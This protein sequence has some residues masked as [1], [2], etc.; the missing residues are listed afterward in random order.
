VSH[1]A[2][3]KNSARLLLD[4]YEEIKGA[5]CH[6]EDELEA[7]RLARLPLAPEV[8]ISRMRAVAQRNGLSWR[9]SR[10]RYFANPLNDL[11]AQPSTPA[12][13]PSQ[14][15]DLEPLSQEE[16]EQAIAHLQSLQSP[17]QRR[18]VELVLTLEPRASFRELASLLF[19]RMS[20]EEFA[21]RLDKARQQRKQPSRQIHRAS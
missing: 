7:Q 18:R 3:H 11:A 20:G 14:P 13:K 2:D 6:P 1:D 15:A 8:M 10:L 21:R 16:H 9:P 12:P 4:A 17:E 5:K 19:E